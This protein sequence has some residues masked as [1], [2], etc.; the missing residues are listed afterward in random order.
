MTDNVL[1]IPAVIA[2]F[3][4]LGI[5]GAGIATFAKGGTNAAKQSNKLMQWRLAAQFVAVILILAFVAIGRGG[6]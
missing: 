4:V 6:N 3:V 1:F 2:C 5:L